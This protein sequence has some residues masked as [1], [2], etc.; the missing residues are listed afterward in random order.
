MSWLDTVERYIAPR[1][2]LRRMQARFGAD[3]LKRHYEAASVGRR[4]SGWNRSAGD[5]ATVTLGA[6]GPV[7]TAARDLVRNNGYASSALDII[8]DHTIGS[9]YP[10]HSKSSN[11]SGG[12][13]PRRATPMA[14]TTSRA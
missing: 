1:W 6:I 2:H 13:G 9:G 10:P 3:M 12:P 4:T 5:G 7:R 11:G 8:T 14:C